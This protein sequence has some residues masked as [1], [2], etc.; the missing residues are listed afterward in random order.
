MPYRTGPLS[1][2]SSPLQPFLLCSK[3]KFSPLMS[4]VSSRTVPLKG[5]NLHVS[6]LT[7]IYQNPHPFIP[8]H[9]PRMALE[10]IRET[11]KVKNKKYLLE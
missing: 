8:T 6:F 11:F 1:A 5:L 9:L 4:Q 3:I 2:Y 10:T 7:I